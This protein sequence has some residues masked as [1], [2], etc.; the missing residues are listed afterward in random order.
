MLLAVLF[1][2]HINHGPPQNLVVSE[3]WRAGDKFE[4]VLHRIPGKDIDGKPMMLEA[5]AAS[6][7]QDLL[8]AATR[9]GVVLQTV[10]AYRTMAQQVK[11]HRK[12]H[13]LA[14]KPGWSNHQAGLAVDIENTLYKGKR[15]STYWWLVRNAGR[16]GFHQVMSWEPWHWEYTEKP[17][18]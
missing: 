16:F 7:Y 15:T 11:Q 12:N 14:A 6:A 2:L 10:S 8:E 3:G 13:Q 4:I 5:M 18:C 17:A 1:A 9:D